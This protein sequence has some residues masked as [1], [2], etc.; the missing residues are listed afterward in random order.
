MPR[1]PVAAALVTASLLV[2]TPMPVGGRTMA[3]CT[4]D[5]L[6]LITID[7]DGSPVKDRH[8]DPS[9]CAHPWC[10]SRRRTN[11]SVRPAVSP[12]L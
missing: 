12:C 10:A 1:S 6:K 2:G 9:P 4:G 3:V 7:A 8:D 11:L 5:G